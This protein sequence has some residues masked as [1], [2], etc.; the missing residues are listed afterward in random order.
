MTDFVFKSSWQMSLKFR[1]YGV[2]RVMS[3]VR[4][5]VCVY[6]RYVRNWFKYV[7]LEAPR[8]QVQAALFL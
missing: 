8:V 6:L 1:N 5:Y 3:I 2:L 4:T 7:G